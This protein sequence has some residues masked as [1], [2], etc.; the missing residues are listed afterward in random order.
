[1]MREAERYD[2]SDIDD[3]M[4]RAESA[5]GRGDAV[6]GAAGVADDAVREDDGMEKGLHKRLMRQAAGRRD[7]WLIGVCAAVGAAAVAVGA[8][9]LSQTVAAVFERGADVGQCMSLLVVL[10]VAWALRVCVSVAEGVLAGRLAADMA[11][12]FRGRVARAL[13]TGQ[14][15]RSVRTEAGELVTSA[16]RGAHDVSLYY[17][18]FLPQAVRAAVIVPLLVGCV[19]VYDLPSAALLAVTIPLLPLFMMLIGFLAKKRSRHQW[20]EMSRLGAHLYDVLAGL[21]TLRLFGRSREQ[22]EVVRRMSRAFAEQ[23]MA[24]LKVAFLSAFVLELTATLATAMV[25][26]TIGLRLVYGEASFAESFFILLLVPEVYLPLRRVGS[27]FHTAVVSLPAASRLYRLID[28]QEVR[29]AC[30]DRRR[31]CGGAPQIELEGIVYDYEGK[32]ALSGAT[33]TVKAGCVTALVGRS[34]S[35]KTTLL[36]LTAGLMRP[37]AGRITIDGTPIAE[38]DESALCTEVSYALQSV[39][40]FRRSVADNILL[41]G[42]DRDRAVRAAVRAGADEFIRTLPKGYDTMLG[43]GGHRLSGGEVRRIALARA[44]AHGGHIL[45]L[46]EWTEGLDAV[47]ESALMREIERQ[48]GSSTVLMAAHRLS[49]AMRADYVAVLDGGRVVEYGVPSE[50]LLKDGAFARLVHKSKEEE[51]V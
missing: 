47:T 34:G 42:S 50:L 11:S 21:G 15:S 40:L 29:A 48:K 4:H 43:D 33:L 41:A 1:M 36:K 30:G 20:R 16:L 12:Y 14:V 13:C 17:A 25:A 10:L 38:W 31:A 28:G 37:K 23:T 22:A 45:L 35:G 24:V 8:Y 51:S 5:S 9:T 32:G 49:V 19:A 46:D 44:F 6:R 18:Q 39:H 26:V 27:Q 3:V 2:E 7:F